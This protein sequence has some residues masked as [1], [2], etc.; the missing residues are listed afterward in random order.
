[1]MKRVYRAVVLAVRLRSL[2]PSVAWPPRGNPEASQV[3]QTG[4]E[5]AL[6]IAVTPCGL[7]MPREPLAFAPAGPE[8][9]PPPLEDRGTLVPVPEPLEPLERP[10]LARSRAP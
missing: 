9:C 5:D 10:T 4:G 7:P 6:R 8:V 3:A 1:M 2:G